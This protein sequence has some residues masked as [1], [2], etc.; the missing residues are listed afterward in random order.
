MALK[1]YSFVIQKVI[2][3]SLLFIAIWVF[4][5][6][7]QIAAPD[8]LQA[9]R[10]FQKADSLQTHARY[11][12]SDHYFN[13]AAELFEK[14]GVWQRVIDSQI[15][16]GENKI[17]A[18]RYERAKE[19]ISGTGKL[20]QRY[21]AD[22]PA[23]QVKVW[24]LLARLD[25]EQSRYQQA[26]AH[27]EKSLTLLAEHAGTLR[28]LRAELIFLRGN[29]FDSQGKYEKALDQYFESLD[30]GNRAENPDALFTGQLY[31]SIGVTYQKM[32]RHEMALQY[33][34]KSIDIDR[35]ALGPNHPDVSAGLNNIAIIKYYQGDY[36]QALDYMKEATQTLSNYWGENHPQV[37]VGYNN[38]SIV[39]SEMG[40]LQ[41]AI[42]Y[43]ERS[44][45]IK[46]KLIGEVNLD[47]AIGYQNLGALHY[48]LE[49]YDQAIAN[50]HKALDLHR[51][52]FDGGHPEIANVYANLG[53]A[54]TAKKEYR[55]ALEYLQKDL[56]MNTGL[57]GG[58][59][60]FIADT[61]T[62]IGQNFEHLDEPGTALV[63]YRKAISILVDE[64]AS[65]SSSQ[66]Q[67]FDS[68]THPV[69][70][71]EA[72]QGK[73][74]AHRSLFLQDGRMEDLRQA[75][76]TYLDASILIRKMQT[77]Y[78][79]DESKLMLGTRADEIYDAGLETSY[80]LYEQTGDPRQI[81][82][83]LYFAEQGKA[84]VLLEQLLE[85]NAQSFAGIP[86]SLVAHERNI[87][88][89]L[90]RLHRQI[91]EKTGQEK[92]IDSVQTSALQDSVYILKQKLNNHIESL[93][94]TYPEYHQLKYQ[95]IN[96]TPQ[97]IQ[98]LLEPGQTLIEYSLVKNEVYAFVI[99]QE[100]VTLKKME[101]DS[102]LA[103]Q[104]RNFRQAV[105][106]E[107]HQ[108]YTELSYTLY[109]QL[110]QP[111]ESSISGNSLFIIP[112]GA[113]HYLPFEALISQSAG[114]TGDYTS[115]SYL[116]KSFSISYSPSATLVKYW[117]RKSQVPS[118]T[119]KSFLAFAPV[120]SSA[121]MTASKE[122][123]DRRLPPRTA[124]PLSRYEVQQV[125]SIMSMQG[126]GT[127]LYLNRQA[128]ERA[129]KASALDRY[130]I[131][132]L[133]THAYMADD[134]EIDPG[135]YFAEEPDLKED[136]I[137]RLEEVYNLNLNAKLVVLSACETGLG[138]F[139]EGEGVMSLAR[140][141]EYAGAQNL[142]VSLWK[143]DDRSTAELMIEFYNSMLVEGTMREAMRQA[144]LHL[145]ND[146]RY[147]SPRFWAPFILLG[148]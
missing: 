77:D 57:L 15:N 105:V 114:G 132:H 97:E 27:L 36:Q 61:H 81:Q 79:S 52:I 86:D 6:E 96:I 101:V 148:R 128:S 11:D 138:N 137:L 34:Q 33:L 83:A 17:E 51:Q 84:Q 75:F 9:H 48:D 119:D 64:S 123:Q 38:I 126:Y 95:D 26:M 104:V 28:K 1:R 146:R 121:E 5:A 102:T 45:A 39:Y 41:E 92:H 91:K 54:Y 133:A 113:L 10:L 42:S 115:L 71:M 24:Q 90:T 118:K 43:M 125:D 56:E 21:A 73:G 37:A 93:E 46:R 40:Q 70:L 78:R 22:E 2:S 4:R 63:H 59:H 49:E 55:N 50:Y 136:G 116:L 98:R 145:M 99:T 117:S 53:E 47:V 130:E 58:Q 32:A 111:L 108:A 82:Y 89:D 18:G 144:K 66:N 134:P 14:H 94:Q 100:Q 135:I 85:T 62:K 109:R 142:L 72:L 87:R 20:I 19:I 141:F 143:V 129:F 69:F 88:R 112:D 106:D 103:A 76:E 68:V 25:I 7:A 12:S 140:A 29:V 147:A 3:I 44:I 31:N 13:R 120:F 23:P 67:S 127:D 16:L 74:S 80:D 107:N 60:P 110:F 30:L 131:I 122:S 139:Y 8:T 35:Q 124:L 65:E